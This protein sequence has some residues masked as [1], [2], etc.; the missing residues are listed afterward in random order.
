MQLRDGTTY[1]MLYFDSEVSH[2][3][4]PELP[5]LLDK[6]STTFFDSK[7]L[8]TETILQRPLRGFIQIP[9]LLCGHLI[10]TWIPSASGQLRRPYALPV[11]VEAS[12]DRAGDMPGVQRENA[13][14]P[15][16]SIE[17]ILLELDECF[18]ECH[19]TA[20]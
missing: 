5:I 10:A 16:L 4:Q 7:P 13:K 3:Y 15:M 19:Y 20:G 12:P 17:R 2:A 6:Q 11:D 18:D 8:T 1:S 14:L 9:S